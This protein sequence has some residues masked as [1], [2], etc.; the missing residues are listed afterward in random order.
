MNRNRIFSL[1][2]TMVLSISIIEAPVITR[3][4]TVTTK[5]GTNLQ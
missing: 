5:I 2:L 3:A 4:A 1:V